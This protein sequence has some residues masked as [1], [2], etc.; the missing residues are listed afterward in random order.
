MLDRIRIG[1]TRTLRWRI[2]TDFKAVPLSGR[3]LTL[4]LVDPFK[5][6]WKMPFS[7]EDTNVIVF[8]YQG[9]HQ[10]VLGTYSMYLYENMGK[11]NQAVVG[12]EAF[13]LVK[14]TWMATK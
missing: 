2:N 3:D 10:S 1:N 9:A 4:V 7:I 5:K 6:K 11:S 12:R 13:E 14:R 8:T